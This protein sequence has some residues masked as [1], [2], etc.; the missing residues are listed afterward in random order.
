[1]NPN[2]LYDLIELE[3]LDTNLFRGQN[4]P[5]SWGRVFGGQVLAQSL[6]AA[7]RSVP[8]D[9]HLHSMHGYFILGGD[10]AAPIIYQVE[11][12]RDGKS[13]NT[14]RVVAFQH[15]KAIFNMSASFQVKEEGFSHQ[16]P[17]PQVTSYKDLISDEE[18]AER[19][20][21]KLPEFYKN[22]IVKRHIEIRQVERV[23]ILGTTPLPPI[24]HIWMKSEEPLPDH[25]AF[26]KQ[27]LA[28]AS[29][30]NL[31]STSALP[32]RGQFKPGQIMMTSLDHAMWFHRAFRADQ[33]LLFEVES[34]VTNGSR[35][36][37]RGSFFNEQGELVASVT[38]EGLIRLRKDK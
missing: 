10:L 1:M 34:T 19:N 5:A 16:Y 24:R 23:D 13:F 30:Y 26:H 7:N 8:E 21:D 36:F 12:I 38:Q 18:W 31:M 20:A 28:F 37:N 17:M 22:L 6:N 27:V 25:P 15:G 14:R 29:D 2:P 33:W 35:G 3:E 4:Y 9:R 32:H 11:C